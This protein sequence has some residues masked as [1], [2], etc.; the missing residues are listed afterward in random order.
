MA[1]CAPFLYTINSGIVYCPIIDIAIDILPPPR[2]HELD[3]HE[4]PHRLPLT[5]VAVEVWAPPYL[6]ER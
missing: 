4:G 5:R 2:Q 3:S 1:V 6:R